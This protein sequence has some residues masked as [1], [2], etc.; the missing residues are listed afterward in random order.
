MYP[1][2]MISL[3]ADHVAAFTLWPAGPGHTRIQCDF[4]FHPGEIARETFD[5]SDA[6][7]VWDIVNRQDWRIC[8][9]VQR[10]LGSRAYRA[11]R[12]SVRR[13]A[14][15]QL[16]HQLLAGDLLAIDDCDRVAGI[17]R[18]PR[19]LHA[20][21]VAEVLLLEVRFVRIGCGGPRCRRGRI[22]AAF[23][24]R[25]SSSRRSLTPNGTSW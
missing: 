5:P 21:N 18:D 23:A 19:L 6:V 2:L 15:E 3:A 16:F 11:G 12:L 7:E 1:N 25:T 24:T 22:I 13:E 17:D 14:G 20:G 8:E 10:G 9:S 4:L